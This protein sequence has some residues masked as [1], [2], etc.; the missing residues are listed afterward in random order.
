MKQLKRHTLPL[1]VIASMRALV[2]TGRLATVPSC[3]GIITARI[4]IV[5]QNEFPIF[6]PFCWDHKLPSP[7]RDDGLQ[8][9]VSQNGDSGLGAQSRD[10]RIRGN[11]ADNTIFQLLFGILRKVDEARVVS[12][13]SSVGQCCDRRVIPLCVGLHK[14]I[15]TCALVNR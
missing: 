10:V 7:V 6:M 13:V 2:S 8:P 15:W 3:H 1:E 11:D 5:G 9:W 12:F 14:H 4:C